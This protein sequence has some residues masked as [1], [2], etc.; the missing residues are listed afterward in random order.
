MSRSMDKQDY[1]YCEDCNMFVDFWK[2]SHNIEDAGHQG[3]H[4]RYVTDEELIACIEDCKQ[5]GCFSEEGVE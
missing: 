3:C 5:C 2:Y 4:W 1:I